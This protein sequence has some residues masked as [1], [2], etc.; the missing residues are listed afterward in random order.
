MDGKIETWLED[1]G[2]GKYAATFLENDVDLRALPHLTEADLRELGVSLG[3]R[4]IMLAAIAGFGSGSPSAER[5]L[6]ARQAGGE[7]DRAPSHSKTPEAERR[8]LTILF[9]DLVG[10]T[11][12]I[13]KLDPEDARDVLRR[14]QDVVAGSIT[15]Y[16]GHV[17]KYLGDG[18]LAYF[19]W[20]T[21]HEDQAEWAVRAG[22]EALD[23]VRSVTLPNGIA[24]EAR[25][26]IATGVV[27][28][29]DLIGT[30]GRETSAVAGHTPNLAARLQQEAEPGQLLIGEGTVRLVGGVFVTEDLGERHLKGV[31]QPV[32]LYRVV[33]EREV[34]S[35]FEA[36]RGG[37]LTPLIG[38]MHEIGLLRDR[39]DLACLGEGQAIFVSGEAG[40]GKSRL[41]Q[42]LEDDVR[43]SPHEVIRIQCSPYH[44]NSALYPVIQRLMRVAGFAPDDSIEKR[45]QRLE[46]L[47]THNNEDVPSVAPIYAELL[48]LDAPAHY[49][50]VK[51]TPQ[52]LKE[53]TLQ[54]LV[55]RLVLISQRLPVLMIVEDTHWIDPSTAELLERIVARIADVRAMIVITHRPDWSA[56]WIAEHSHTTMLSIG[57]LN[58][59]QTAELIR[60][61]C[62]SR[63][64]SRA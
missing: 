39:W 46:M 58:R 16:S 2:L 27:V 10:S 12:I 28:V 37:A 62:R 41:V 17:A 40:I 20:P 29:G 30:S 48:S 18:V 14:F 45:L 60:G 8:L 53:M 25:A 56:P 35:R 52:Q 22:L 3:H 34:D 21:A 24:L 6:E 26:G 54:T 5:E 19:G 64:Q 55:N 36:V 61:R 50:P 63:A 59:S 31:E 15:R 38:R 13:E 47:L 42:V 23:A 51:L 49:Q 32:R 43:G 33:A 4:K 1:L 9:C 57:R 7:G 44:E 11:R